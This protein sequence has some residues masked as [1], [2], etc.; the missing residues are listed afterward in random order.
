MIYSSFWD[1]PAGQGYNYFLEVCSLLFLIA[2]TL[3]H[4]LVKKIPGPINSLY[5]VALI[6]AI[7]DLSLDIA[8]CVTVQYADSVPVLANELINGFF[9]AFQIILPV[10]TAVYIIY[11]ARFSF[12]D[13]WPLLMLIPAAAFFVV[14]LINPATHLVFEFSPDEAGHIVMKHGI[15]F[16]MFYA[17]AI[18]YVLSTIVMTLIFRKRIPAQVVFVSI[19]ISAILVAGLVIQSFVPNLILTGTAIT[20]TMLIV[21]FTIIN[22]SEMVDNFSGVFNFNAYIDY[23]NK[24]S[25]EKQYKFFTMIRVNNLSDVR[26]AY[27]TVAFNELVS[28]I[29]TYFNSF[30]SKVY[31]FRSRT[32]K[33]IVLTKDEATQD[34][35][36]N[37]I[38]E[39]F[40][41]PFKIYQ[42]ELVLNIS[43]FYFENKG[44][45]K[46]GDKYLEFQDENGEPCDTEKKDL[47]HL[48]DAYMERVYRNRRIKKILAEALEK[49]DSFSMV[50][51]PIY[52]ISQ[53]KFNHFEALLRLN[54]HPE[55]GYIGPGEF[56]PIAEKSG[57]APDIDFWVLRETCNFLKRHEEIE[58]LEINISCAEFFNN[59]SKKFL[60]IIDEI[61]VDHNRIC[62]ELTETVATK[63]PD[64]LN[65]FM[66]DLTEN[67]IKFAIDDFGTG[68]SNVAR[69]VTMPFSLTKLDK[70][71]LTKED[72]VEKFLKSAV[73]L[74]NSLDMPM[75][76]EGVETDEQ[77]ETAK[78]YNINY[79]QGYYFS[80]PLSENDLIDLL[81]KNNQK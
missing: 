68:Y 56:I 4:F 20:M 25:F 51:Q 28:K 80:K 12:K 71:L 48:T 41:K 49:P 14:L 69:S 53:K 52:D 79:V 2:L 57:L 64:K 73:S 18:F 47:I 17:I 3:R 81:K 74:F 54:V 32:N 43:M 42:H 63:Y 75:V 46:S 8:G 30:G 10:F 33:F 19:L 11:S 15:L 60:Q 61:G 22:P 7:I 78:K 21:G 26:E 77:L 29:G 65:Q 50:Y 34:K 13:K 24:Q 16:Y 67:G 62:I 55:L 44:I 70:S 35:V 1:L 6:C 37:S 9:Y 76:I 72:R 27:G 31:V 66:K 59:P 23:L 36:V 5:G 39:R 40:K 58:I 45:F 38:H